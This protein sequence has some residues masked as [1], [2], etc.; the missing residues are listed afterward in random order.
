MIVGVSLQPVG[1][2]ST[3]LSA[4]IDLKRGDRVV[5]E[6]DAG[7]CFAT[8]EIEPHSP[9]ATLDLRCSN[10]CCASPMNAICA[11]RMK[12]VPRAGSQA[13]VRRG[14]PPARPG[15]E[16]G[17]RQLHLR[18]AQGGILL[19]GRK[20]HRLSQPGPR[21]GQRPAGARRDATDR[22]ARR[23]QGDRRNRPLRARV[24]LLVVAA[25]LRGGHGQDGARAGA[26]AQSLAPGRDVRAAQMLPAL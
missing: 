13:D 1:H 6:A 4:G 23:D 26:G 15:D 12:T 25:R 7:T 3:Y 19:R 16:T 24:V 10:R 5:V 8:V 20:A 17:Q 22:R 11:R 18:R 2:I 21:P 9:A 14:N